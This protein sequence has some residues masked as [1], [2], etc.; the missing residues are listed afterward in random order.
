M[1]AGARRTTDHMAARKKKRRLRPRTPSRVKRRTKKG[2]SGRHV[3]VLPV[4]VNAPVRGPLQRPKTSKVEALTVLASTGASKV[5]TRF[6][7]V[8]AVSALRAGATALTPSCAAAGED[9]RESKSSA[10]RMERPRRL[11]VGG[12]GAPG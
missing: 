5:T 11:A 7:A 10:R 9:R 8:D 2:R 12:A 3:A 4:T 6:D 1:R